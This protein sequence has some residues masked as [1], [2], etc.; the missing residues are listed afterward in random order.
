VAEAVAAVV[1]DSGLE[2]ELQPM[3]K[4]RTLDG[5]HAVVLGA[6]FYIGQW[7]KEAHNF[8]A[9][10]QAALAEKPVAI[11]ALGPLSA[12]EKEVQGSRAQ[13]D[14]ALAKHPWL[15]PVALEM[16][17]GK[18]DP[19][20]LNL[21]DRLLTSLPAS[22]LHGLPAIDQRDWAAIRAWAGSLAAQFQPV[23]G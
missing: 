4:V 14:Q 7:H 22:P 17:A 23:T 11:F 10:H 13:L 2:V 18:Y 6:P 9:R 16:F 3:Q 19:A 12:D 5:Y 21:P 20:K 15:R 8:L 1:R